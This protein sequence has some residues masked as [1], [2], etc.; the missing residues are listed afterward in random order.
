MPGELFAL[1][2]AMLFGAGHIAVRRAHDEGWN[3]L[4]C[5]LTVTW[6]NFLIYVL[7]FSLL[8]LTTSLPPI[9]S[10]GVLAFAAAG[11]FTVLLGRYFLFNSIERIGAARAA[12]FRVT[13]PIVTV[14]LAY[15]LLSERLTPMAFVGAAIVMLGVWVL[16]SE[17]S[18]RGAVREFAQRPERVVLIGII[19]GLMS[20]ASF[21]TGQVFRKIGLEYTPIAAFGAMVGSGLAAAFCLAEAL[22]TRKLGEFAKAHR[23]RFAWHLAS[24]GV[25][26]AMAQFSIFLAYE[27]ARVSTASVLGAT[28]P[29]WTL[30]WAALLMR[31]QEAPNWTLA[32][33]VLLIVG[34]SALIVGSG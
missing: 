17:T 33:S 13:S 26:T 34:G 23:A 5:Y 31:E 8:A 27:H 14:S 22:R 7:G 9:R 18:K 6:I 2:G 29:V 10:E 32:L 21:G 24:A 16:T 20:S 4:N 25:V 1:F 19:L 11:L 3:N 15:I 30:S 12:S 28:E